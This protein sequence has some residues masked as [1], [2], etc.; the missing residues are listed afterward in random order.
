MRSTFT[1]P[2]PGSPGYVLVISSLLLGL[3]GIPFFLLGLL[4]IRSD[5][6][7][8]DNLFIAV[9]GLIV[10]AIA[11]PTGISGF[12]KSESPQSF[13]S[14]D[15]NPFERL[16]HSKELYE[17]ELARKE[18]AEA[19]RIILQLGPYDLQSL[20]T[21]RTISGTAPSHD[22]VVKTLEASATTEIQFTN[23]DFQPIAFA[24]R[25]TSAWNY[26]KGILMEGLTWALVVVATPFILLSNVWTLGRIV[27]HRALRL[28]RLARQYRGRSQKLLLHDARQPVLYLRSFSHDDW[29]SSETFLPTTSEEK[30]VRNYNRIGPVIALGNPKERLP[31]LGAS[32][33]Y[34]ED[35][36]I[37]QSAVLYLMSISKLIVIQ[38]GNAPGLLQEIGFARAKLDPEKVIISFTAWEDLDEWT[39]HLQYLRFK[40]FAD[41]L[42]DRKLP[43]DIQATSHLTFDQNW[44][45][46]PQSD[47]SYSLPSVRRKRAKLKR[48]AVNV[49][50]IV[51]VLWALFIAPWVFA[52]I[53][54]VSGVSRYR[55]NAAS[56]KESHLGSTGMSVWLPGDPSIDERKFLAI[57]ADEDAGFIYHSGDLECE[58]HFSRFSENFRLL[59]ESDVR[60]LA[61]DLCESGSATELNKQQVGYGKSLWMGKCPRDGKDYQLTGYRFNRAQNYWWILVLFDS[62]N[63]AASAAAEKILASVSIAGFD[64]YKGNDAHWKPYPIGS[65]SMTVE[66]PD[67]P[68]KVDKTPIAFELQDDNAY[69]YNG[70]NL[71]TL[72]LNQRSI[73][74]ASIDEAGLKKMAGNFCGADATSNL[75][76]HQTGDGQ[77]ELDGKCSRSGKEY[78]LHGHCFTKGENAW[79]IL[80]L[81]DPSEKAAISAVDRMLTSWKTAEQKLAQ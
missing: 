38:A 61:D 48:V 41:V 72:M 39:R 37:W 33:L 44:E 43:E 21:Y 20:E 17:I 1:I 4:A 10:T 32:R 71:L 70:G 62:S 46:K 54:D 22:D 50:P 24:L 28:S 9:T 34:F 7:H 80:A 64:T 35:N 8:A 51:G 74:D 56:W 30:L 67:A 52:K 81:Y 47:L 75:T 42:L 66:L 18:I 77:W 6:F 57:G 23:P 79:L 2:T 55:D 68:I 45:P 26:M 29:E 76:T 65:T 53:V 11:I 59:D 25:P 15:I 16:R 73:G 31:I 60:P 5:G 58:M 40:K 36:S 78:K 49:L 13:L 12:K 14:S 27:M 69:V 19:S 63:N 3:F